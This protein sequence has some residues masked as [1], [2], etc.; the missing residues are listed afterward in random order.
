MSDDRAP[1]VEVRAAV[2]AR[3]LRFHAEPQV[4][5]DATRHGSR[6][7]NLPDE[8]APHVTHEDVR[9]DAAILSWLEAPG[10]DPS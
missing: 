7:T 5:I 1:D 8:V 9:I 2:R 6:R 3:R 4:R 10:D